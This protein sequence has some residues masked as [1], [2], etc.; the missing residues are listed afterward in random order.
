M[1]RGTGGLYICYE[2][3]RFDST[4]KSFRKWIEIVYSLIYSERWEVIQIVVI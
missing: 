1:G 4:F 2:E 3:I